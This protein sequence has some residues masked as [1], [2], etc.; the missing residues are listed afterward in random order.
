MHLYD[1]GGGL[2]PT[3][4]TP[5][6]AL[7]A[8]PGLNSSFCS[9]SHGARR[10]ISDHIKDPQAYL[11]AETRQAKRNEK[12]KKPFTQDHRDATMCP[13][14]SEELAR[15]KEIV[16]YIMRHEATKEDSSLFV[17]GKRQELRRLASLGL[18][19]HQPAIAAYCQTTNEES[20]SI[21]GSILTQQNWQP[22]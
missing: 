9:T 18:L 19:G 6:M 13:M 15:F 4:K 20:D 7:P 21:I 16:R 14:L 10:S 8:P 17:A 2:P 12:T 1:K 3:L 22:Q 11:R 5:I